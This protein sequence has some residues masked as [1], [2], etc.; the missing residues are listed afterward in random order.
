VPF[1]LLTTA[2]DMAFP[3]DQHHELVGGREIY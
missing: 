1:G 2:D 3:T